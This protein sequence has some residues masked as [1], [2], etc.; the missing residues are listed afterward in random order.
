MLHVAQSPA[1]FR[2]TLFVDM[3]A[4]RKHVHRTE[5]SCTSAVLPMVH[6]SAICLPSRAQEILYWGTV[7]ALA[8]W[9]PSTWSWIN[10]LWRPGGCNYLVLL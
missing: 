7:S 9:T 6:G 3:R 8:F 4:C 2:Q 10:P 1:V 5:R